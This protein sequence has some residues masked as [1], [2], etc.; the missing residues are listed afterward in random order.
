MKRET[1]NGLPLHPALVKMA[2]AALAGK[3]D[4]REFLATATALGATTATAYGMLGLAVP[5][6]A[7]AQ[8]VRPGGVI[9]I[10]T[11]VQRMEDPRIFDWSYPGNQARFFCEPLARYTSD[12]TFVPWLL[13]SW[14]I[15][16][17]ATE[18][19]LYLR[20]NAKWTNG[21]DFNADDVVF[22][23]TRWCESQVPS[24]SMASRMATIVEK[25]GEETFVGDVT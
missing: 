9:K 6:R 15:N 11:P 8:E 14:D 3:L 13:E 16:D 12:F 18:Y 20:Q 22:N 1:I 24:N 23:I 21:D 17:D 2:P 4:R 10:A 19:T 25:K 7:F 5:R